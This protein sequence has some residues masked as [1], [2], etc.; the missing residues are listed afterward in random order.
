MVCGE[1]IASL[2][3]PMDTGRRIWYVRARYYLGNGTMKIF[4]LNVCS[5]KEAPVVPQSV[6]L[7]V[8]TPPTI[9]DIPLADEAVA[10]IAPRRSIVH[11]YIVVVALP[12]DVPEIP[13]PIPEEYCVTTTMY[14]VGP[15]PPRT[16]PD[17]PVIPPIAP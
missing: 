4:E 9:P 16:L 8:P 14:V 3:K 7:T 5:I 12:V 10:M 11:P 17:N 1:V 2:N 15:I 13:Q 6:R